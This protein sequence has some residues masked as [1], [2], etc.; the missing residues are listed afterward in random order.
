M[1]IPSEVGLLTNL[2]AI[3]FSRNGYNGTL[4]TELARLTKL[5]QMYIQSTWLTG[6]V[7][8]LC[9]AVTNGTV[10][11]FNFVADQMEMNCSCCTCCLY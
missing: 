7:N 1:Q 9:E 4:P 10:P 11:L 8:V 5:R 3:A 2:E 6:D